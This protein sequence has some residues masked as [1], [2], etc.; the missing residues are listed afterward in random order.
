MRSSP[1]FA[2]VIV[3]DVVDVTCDYARDVKMRERVALCAMRRGTLFRSSITTITTVHAT[4]IRTCSLTVVTAL[5]MLMTPRRVR[6]ETPHMLAY[7]YTAVFRVPFV[8]RTTPPLMPLRLPDFSLPPYADARVYV[9]A[10]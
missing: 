8:M 5:P 2:R 4:R 10:A 7:F 1:C 9:F 3:Y 6:L